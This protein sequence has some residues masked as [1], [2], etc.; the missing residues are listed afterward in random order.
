MFRFLI[1][2][3]YF[4]LRSGA[5]KRKIYLIVFKLCLSWKFLFF[6]IFL[7]LILPKLLFNSSNKKKFRF[8][9]LAK[10]NQSQFFKHTFWVIMFHIYIYISISQLFSLLII[11]LIFGLAA[12]IPRIEQI[13]H[14]SNTRIT[15]LERANFEKRIFSQGQ[16][17]CFF[18]ATCSLRA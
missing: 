6:L 2:L 10:R 17:L 11:Q 1:S 12:G 7:F 9:S 14:F 4:F 5:K 18:G 16:F 8:F 15:S 3:L 13:Q